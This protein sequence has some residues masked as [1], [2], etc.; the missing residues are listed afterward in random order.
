MA[1]SDWF[2]NNVENNI[3]IFKDMANNQQALDP[4]TL[5]SI[6]NGDDRRKDVVNSMLNA[7]V[8][9]RNLVNDAINKG[10]IDQLYQRDIA[11]VMEVQR[12]KE[13]LH[14]RNIEEIRNTAEVLREQQRQINNQDE[15]NKRRDVLAE[16]IRIRDL[17]MQKE[18]NQTKN[19][20][21]FNFYKVA[22]L[23]RNGKSLRDAMIGAGCIK[24]AKYRLDYDGRALVVIDDEHID[25]VCNNSRQNMAFDMLEKN[26][27]VVL[28]TGFD[29]MTNY[30]TCLLYYIPK[31][32]VILFKKDRFIDQYPTKLG[33]L[34]QKRNMMN[35]GNRFDTIALTKTFVKIGFMNALCVNMDRGIEMKEDLEALQLSCQVVPES[36][37]IF[38]KICHNLGVKP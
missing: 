6:T 28:V 8:S 23:I 3:S 18:L 5:M 25:C 29:N 9:H 34:L 35:C 2:K 11:G 12:Q 38:K 24:N 36:M 17:Q 13:M 15:I 14:R 22:E 16:S 7:E 33:K 37:Q 20:E 10:M 30:S 31:F 19:R 1:L 27:K 32:G 26:N 21:S 4:N